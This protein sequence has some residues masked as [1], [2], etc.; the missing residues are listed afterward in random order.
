MP[1]PNP[2]RRISTLLGCS[3]ISD[4]PFSVPGNTARLVTAQPG[5]LWFRNVFGHRG[6]DL[7]TFRIIWARGV[8]RHKHLIQRTR[9]AIDHQVPD[10]FKT[11]PATRID[12]A[13][14]IARRNQPEPFRRRVERIQRRLISTSVIIDPFSQRGGFSSVSSAGTEAKLHSEALCFG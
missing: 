10:R 11:K 13:L 8:R 1:K 4:V 5:V 7:C 6:A 14:H 12:I 2:P 3:A 9:P